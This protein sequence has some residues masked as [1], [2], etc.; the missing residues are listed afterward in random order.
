MRFIEAFKTGWKENLEK[1][2]KFFEADAELR[3]KNQEVNKY[4]K[5]WIVYPLGVLLFVSLFVLARNLSI[6]QTVSKILADRPN[7]FVQVKEGW[8]YFKDPAKK[9]KIT[10]PMRNLSALPDFDVKNI[11][12]EFDVLIPEKFRSHTDL[13]IMIPAIWGRYKVFI[14]NQLVDY[15]RDYMNIIPVTSHVFKLF[16]QIDGENLPKYG[17]RAVFPVVVGKINEIRSF[18]GIINDQDLVYTKALIAQLVALFLFLILFINLPNKPELFIFLMLF[19]TNLVFSVVN[20]FYRDNAT[21]F[22]SSIEGYQY[23]L[24]AISFFRS[25][26]FYC[27]VLEFFR[28]SRKLAMELSSK[29]FISGIVVIPALAL[30]IAFKSNADWHSAFQISQETFFLIPCVLIGTTKI[31]YLNNHLKHRLRAVLGF[32]IV[33]AISYNGGKNIYDYFFIQNTVTT[34]YFN[35]IYMYFAVALVTMLEFARTERDRNLLTKNLSKEVQDRV[36]RRFGKFEDEH[37][38]LIVLVDMIG[39]TKTQKKVG[40]ENQKQFIENVLKHLMK[41]FNTGSKLAGT[42]DGFYFSWKENFTRENILEKL[43]MIHSL[44]N[45][46]LTLHSLGLNDLEDQELKFRCSLG[47]GTYVTGLVEEGKLSTDYTAGLILSELSR[48]IGAGD[49]KSSTRILLNEFTLD[50]LGQWKKS[51]TTIQAKNE[52]MYSFFELSQPEIETLLQKRAA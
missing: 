17:I 11:W 20:L 6:T 2:W 48:I 52:E 40:F 22:F 24:A 16:I 46:K 10:L 23:T 3:R 4:N 51:S 47:Y 5:K 38:G 7:D 26:L 37:R 8:V 15:G 19:I 41:H 35:H 32:L 49:R 13:G 9:T 25:I 21:K 31:L 45:T 42:G 43:E 1:L 14:D 27:F 50:L 33:A 28:F 30:G 34:E 12:Y 44:L 39:F 29:L 36:T 18:I